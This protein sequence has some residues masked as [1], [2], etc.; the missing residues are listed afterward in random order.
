MLVTDPAGLSM[1]VSALDNTALVGIDCET[2]GLDPHRDRVRLLSV[3]TD[4]IDGT[5]FTYI[6]DCFKIDPASLWETLASKD[7][8]LHN[9]IFDLAFLARMGFTPAAKVQDT[10]LI[11]RVLYA[12]TR[13]RHGLADCIKRELGEEMAKEMQK[14]EWAATLTDEQLVYAAKDA[15]VLRPLM[16]TLTKKIAE[17]KLEQ[18]AEIES[19][20]LPAVAWMASHGVAVDQDA[21]K[22]L[23]AKAKAEG[24]ALREQMAALAP[25]PPGEM[26]V[27][28]KFDSPAD[29]TRLFATLG[30]TITDTADET[31]AGINHPIAALLRNY[32]EATKRLT[33]Y[34]EQ[35]LRNV[36]EGRVFAH[37]NQLGA[38]ASGR[39]SCSGPNLQQLPRDPTYRRCIIAPAGRVLVKADYSQVELRIAAKVSGDKAMLKA[40]RDGLDLHTLTAR[41]VLGVEEVTKEH[42]QIAKSLNFGL[43]YGMGA[44]GLRQ[45]AAT[46]FGVKLTEEEAVSYRAAFFKTYPG[47]RS[48]HNKTGKTKDTAVATRT[49]AGRRR[50][51]VTRFTEKLNTPVQGT[52]ADGLK[53]ALALLWERRGDMPGAF[54]VLAV[55]DEVVLEADAGQADAAAAWLKQAMMDAMAP[56]VAPVPV[57]VDVKVAQTWGGD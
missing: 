15:A 57:E 38:E 17:A 24:V 10:V 6:I 12:G 9:A 13:E 4:T 42:R 51:D 49:L 55:H 34:G 8:V 18:T 29:V 2:T 14:S 16:E 23:A 11:S 28:W 19:R 44:P 50:L 54:P 47:L 46:N 36:Y 35:W 25:V 56:L 53:L 31:L 26:F 7:L 30:I 37:W 45:Y 33:T 21:W 52:G 20:C 40:Y 41:T 22:A 43:L 27:S 48:W 5:T 1:V 3:A 39:F 32:R